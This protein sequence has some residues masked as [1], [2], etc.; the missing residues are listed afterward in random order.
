MPIKQ[1]IVKK[2]T[3]REPST[4]CLKYW[5]VI[6]KYI[7][8]EYDVSEIDL[9]MLL[10]LYSEGL[11]NYYKFV[12]YSNIFGWDKTRFKR[13]T[14]KGMIHLFRE[15]DRNEY[16]LYEVTRKC[17]HMIT[18]MYKYMFMEKEIPENPLRSKIFR[19]TGRYSD[20]VLAL[21]IKKFNEEV[22]KK[23]GYKVTRY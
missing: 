20:K 6:R 22:R 10:Y 19:K 2:Y 8:T 3:R 12:E 11:F 18:N 4:D 13:L 23:V 9:E 1:S 7:Q 21:S 14:D 17:R 15:K 16:R 5:R